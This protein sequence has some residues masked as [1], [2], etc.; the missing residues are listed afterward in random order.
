[1]KTPICLVQMVE[2]EMSFLE[3]MTFLACTKPIGKLDVGS[4][5][6]PVHYPQNNGLKIS[7][8]ISPGGA[9]MFVAMPQPPS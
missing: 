3:E 5:L 9:A 1:M 8:L 7:R 6:N 2:R 4:V